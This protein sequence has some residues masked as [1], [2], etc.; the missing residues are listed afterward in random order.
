MDSVSAHYLAKMTDNALSSLSDREAKILCMRFG[1]GLESEHTIDE[2]SQL[3]KITPQA[4]R[5]IEA[6]AIKVLSQ[7]GNEQS[8][9]LFDVLPKIK[10]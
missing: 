1:I 6:K 9:S 4:V 3:F 7:P 8:K 5:Q 10:E 2:I